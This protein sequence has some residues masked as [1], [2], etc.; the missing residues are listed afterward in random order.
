MA[1]K[2]EISSASA[3]LNSHIY[4]DK[5]NMGPKS[6][7]ITMTAA[8]AIELA[9]NILAVAGAKNADG[10][11]MVTGHPEKKNLVTVLRRGKRPLEKQPASHKKI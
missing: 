6:F 1:E 7:T 11:I 4:A 10:R 8:Q 3:K 9:T 2:T 5:L